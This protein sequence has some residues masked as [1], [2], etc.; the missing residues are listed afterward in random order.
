M[1]MI[2]RTMLQLL[3]GFLLL[4]VAYRLIIP[5]PINIPNNISTVGFIMFII[6]FLLIRFKIELMLFFYYILSKYNKK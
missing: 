3:V 6:F 5:K 1:E 4:R 2:P